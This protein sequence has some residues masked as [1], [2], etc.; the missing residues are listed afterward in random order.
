MPPEPPL[1]Q[2]RQDE[3]V[4]R[5]IAKHD[6]A[7]FERSRAAAD[8]LTQRGRAAAEA[9]LRAGARAM[10]TASVC[11]LGLACVCF[12]AF[13]YLAVNGVTPFLVEHVGGLDAQSG[14]G[15]MLFLVVMGL[16]GVVAAIKMFSD[17]RRAFGPRISGT[18]R[19]KR[20]IADGLPGRAIVT[21]YKEGN[22]LEPNPRFDLVLRIELA[23]RPA[24]VLKRRERVPC[25]SVV[26]TGAELPVFVD[27]TRG[28]RVLVDWETAER[29]R[30]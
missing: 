18:R 21:S 19:E 7:R 23:G 11:A 3:L 29:M 16:A 8:E 13:A 15:V 4:A 10:T 30:R 1:D 27:P 26:T 24:Y 22:P 14:P 5:A 2:A 25:P 6:A 12:A 17:A 28:D 9:G 20:L